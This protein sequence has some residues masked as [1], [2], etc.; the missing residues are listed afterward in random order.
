MH[1]MTIAIALIIAAGCGDD[2]P[3]T[4]TTPTIPEPFPVVDGVYRGV[5]TYQELTGFSVR[6]SGIIRIVQLGDQV[7]VT[8]TRGGA[9]RPASRISFPRTADRDGFSFKYI[10]SRGTLSVTGHAH[11]EWTPESDDRD[12]NNHCGHYT[13]TTGTLTFSERRML[14]KQNFSS[15]QCGQVEV[16]GTLSSEE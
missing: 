15:E 12:H 3:T 2:T 11:L 14:Y 6:G 13:P 16:A 5:V 7:A 8:T 10:K 9:S 1:R 4:P